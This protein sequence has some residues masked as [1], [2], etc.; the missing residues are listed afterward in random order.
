MAYRKDT[1]K[2]LIIDF[3]GG[4]PTELTQLAPTSPK[5][6]WDGQKWVHPDNHHCHCAADPDTPR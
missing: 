1:G 2:R 3:L 6:T 4:L 5:D